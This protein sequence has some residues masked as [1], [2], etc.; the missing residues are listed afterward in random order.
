MIASAATDDPQL[1]QAYLRA[2]AALRLHA[3]KIGC[4][5][6]LVM[7]P[8]GALLDL[9]IYPRQFTTLVW[10]RV[11]GTLVVAVVLLLH[12]FQFARERIRSL[13]MTYI[14]VTNATMSLMVMLTEGARSPYYTGLNLVLMGMSVAIPFSMGET[15]FACTSTLAIYIAAC[16]VHDWRDLDLRLLSCWLLL[17]HPHQRGLRDRQLLCLA[18]ALRGLPG[19]AT[20]STPRIANSPNPIPNCPRWTA[21]AASSSPI[22]AMSCAPR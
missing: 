6:V 22:S 7:V 12:R 19:C 1:A 3:S 21:C 13:N 10:I 2:D 14:L 5:L 11:V 15:A 4:I 20:S 18:P 9:L 16:L 8:L 17:H